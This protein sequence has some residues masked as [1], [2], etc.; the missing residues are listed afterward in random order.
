MY[1]SSLSCR[2]SELRSAAAAAAADMRCRLLLLL[3]FLLRLH[4]MR[5]VGDD[6]EESENA[7]PKRR[8][9]G[10]WHSSSS[11]RRRNS[12]IVSHDE[13]E[14]DRII[15]MTTITVQSKNNQYGE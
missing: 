7:L 13:E 14:L 12:D 1:L 2:R 15:T 3:L 9:V 6:L 5:A 4:L 11:S 8:M 10:R